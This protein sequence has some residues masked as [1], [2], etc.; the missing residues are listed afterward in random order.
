MPPLGSFYTALD[1]NQVKNYAA[2][3]QVRELRQLCHSPRHFK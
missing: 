2:L 3:L 1:S